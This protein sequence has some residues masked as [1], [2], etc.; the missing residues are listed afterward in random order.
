MGG[1]ERQGRREKAQGLLWECTAEFRAS[2]PALSALFLQTSLS[3]AQ[4]AAFIA[5]AVLLSG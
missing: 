2:A 3:R 4:I 1:W 5:P